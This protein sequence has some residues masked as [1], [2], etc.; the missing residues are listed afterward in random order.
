MSILK[1]FNKPKWQSPNEQVRI[2]AIQSSDDPEL[3]TS[4]IDIV[5]T[6]VSS[7]VQRAALGKIVRPNDLTQIL[8]NHP[9]KTIKKLASKK[10]IHWFED[11]TDENQVNLFSQINDNETIKTLAETAQNDE[12]RKQA[13]THIKQQGLLSQLLVKEKSPQ[14]QKLIIDKIEQPKSLEKLLN[15]AKKNNKQLYQLISEKLSDQLELDHNETAIKLCKKLENVVHGKSVDIKLSEIN[16]HWQSIANNVDEPIKLRFNGAIEAA[17]MILDPEHRS[18]FLLKQKLQRSSAMLNELEQLVTKSQSMTLK[19]AQIAITKYQ[20]Y[21]EIDFAIGEFTRY[22]E[23]LAQLLQKRDDIQK[24]EQ[25]PTAATNVLDELNK[26]LTKQIIQ[27]DQLNK[28][29]K[30][31]ARA[32]KNVKSSESL[33]VIKTQFTDGTLKLAEKI[34]QSAQIR[35]KAAEQAIELIEPTT[36]QIKEGHLIKAK[37]MINQIAEHKK[38]AGFSHPTIKKNK[39]QLDS[40]WQQLKDLRNWQKWS[41]DKARQDIIEELHAMVGKGQH[42]DAVLKKLKDA[43][44][45]W[46]ALEDMEK[47]PGDKFPSRNQKMWQEF[48]VVSKALFEPTQPFFEKRSEQQGGYL[49]EIEAHIKTMTDTDLSET[50]ERDLARLSRDAIKHLKSLD[51]LPPKKRGI[52]AKALRKAITRV[53]D[54]LNEFY[55]IAEKKKLKLIDEAQALY[56]VEDHSAAI[57]SAKQLQHQWKSAGIVKQHT[58]RKLW[59]K[60]RKAND[61]IF[62]RREKESQEKQQ[63]NQ[64]QRKIAHELISQFTL[65]LKKIKNQNKLSE[66]KAELNKQWHAIDKPAN[67]LEHE[68]QHLLQNIDEKSAQFKADIILKQ[69]KQKQ[70]IDQVL[71][72]FESGKINEDKKSELLDKLLDDELSTFFKSRIESSSGELNLA[73]L[74]IQA[75]FI[76]G[77]ETPKE[78]LEDRMAYQVKVLSERMSGE[79][80]SNDQE[81]TENWLTQWYLTPKTDAEYMKSNSKRIKSAIK[82]MMNQLS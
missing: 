10:L 45:R 33:N 80:L 81:Q 38:T 41:N 75:E 8:A 78:F 79:K 68:Y 11:S 7:K 34:E 67:M 6:D 31:W 26:E 56:D 54:K 62:K 73:E 69:Q 49:E 50:S 58:E 74:L 64:Q 37:K 42:P 57:E 24:D 36:V 29:K 13:I 46:Y 2:T 32:I 1:W 77:L 21:S 3:L 39:Y 15:K 71:T 66:C 59:K 14:L 18:Q 70:K 22:Q 19:Q 55:S 5:N 12:V 61:A 44:E 20:D 82:A 40:V 72:D 47:L 51:R 53:D 63:E 65:Q 16:E 9:D 76:T 48:R 60:F 4:L 28:F 30:R 27:P 35:Q 52:T 43:N 23:A 17:K 25:I